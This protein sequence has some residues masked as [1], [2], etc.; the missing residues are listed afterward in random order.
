MQV[1]KR[2][3]R[4]WLRCCGGGEEKERERERGREREDSFGRR[5]GWTYPRFVVRVCQE[6]WMSL[7]KGL[8]STRFSV[9]L[10]T[11][12]SHALSHNPQSAQTGLK[13]FNHY[14]NTR[15]HSV[16]HIHPA[17]ATAPIHPDLRWHPLS[18]NRAPS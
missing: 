8:T 11:K 3:G 7:L 6:K 4:L 16:F 1:V 9:Y 2:R 15:S 14:P 18:T 13:F 17:T 12:T 10:N 5:G